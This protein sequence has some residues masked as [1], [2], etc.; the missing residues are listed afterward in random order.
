MYSWNMQDPWHTWNQSSWNQ[1]SR[2]QNI[3]NQR[4]WSQEGRDSD[5]EHLADSEALTWTAAKAF[6][7]GCKEPPGKAKANAILKTCRAQ[8]DGLNPGQ[9]VWVPV[10][11]N[12]QAY[13]AKH[14]AAEQIFESPITGFFAEAFPFKEPNAGTLRNWG[15]T[16]LRVDF[17]CTHADHS[18]VR[19]HPS[20]ASE[21]KVQIGRLVRWRQ[22]LD[23]QNSMPVHEEALTVI[24]HRLLAQ[25]SEP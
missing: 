2:D 25:N 22:G 15:L 21:A 18:A 24:S 11:F 13:L 3:S 6:L 19:L 17:V 10:E 4:S 1:N 20:K 14:P 12:W 23:A 5:D 8:I 7:S 9:R 16:D